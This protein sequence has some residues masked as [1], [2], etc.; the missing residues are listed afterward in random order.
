VLSAAL[1]WTAAAL[2]AQSSFGTLVGLVKNPAKAQV[3]GATVTITKL[4][5]GTIR[6]TISGSDGMYSFSDV[7]PG[8]YSVSAQSEGYTD[9]TLASLQVIAG[10]ATRAD[11]TMTGIGSISSASPVS[12][13]T[14]APNPANHVVSNAPVSSSA[15]SNASFNKR[16]SL[17]H[18][19]LAGTRGTSDPDEPVMTASLTP[20]ASTPFG[21]AGEIATAD[22]PSFPS[23]VPGPQA[24]PAAAAAP[25]APAAPADAP[26]DNQTPFA[27]ADFTWMNAV[28][29]NHDSV[30]DGKYFSGEF[31]VDTN[32][33]F[34]GNHPIDHT[35]G[36]TTEGTR[37]GEIVLQEL[38]IGGD[39]HWD[40]MQGR[41]LF[42]IGA[43]ATAV[44]RNDA[45]PS[46]GQWDIANACRYISEGYAGYHM[47]VQHGLNF[48]AGIFMSYIG[49]FS[50]YSFDNWSYQPSYVS[51]NTPWFFNGFRVQWFPTNKLKFEPW[52]INGW[53]SYGKFNGKP[54]VGGQI[55]WR[56]TGNL[57]FVWN[58]Y[59]LGQDTIA[60]HR[61][62]LHE[63]DSLE[64]KYYDNPNK[65]MH[66][67]AVSFTFDVGCE[68]GG[69]TVVQ[70][71]VTPGQK[72]QCFTNNNK[73]GIPAQNFIGAMAYQRW[74]F[75]HDKFGA[76]IGGGWMSNEGRYL[77]LLPPINGA[78]AI[79]GTPYFTQN[80]GQKFAG[81]D[82]Q[83]TFDWMP[84]QFVTWRFEFTQRGTNVPYF[85]G[86]GGITPPGGNN[87]NPGALAY[88]PDGS[89]WQPD[90]RKDE[91]RFLISLMVHL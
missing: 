8:S 55:L 27:F 47:D 25:A 31:R 6:A 49:L 62:R 86:P 90:L 14:A 70:G 38:N 5:G 60:T 3:A 57:D 40:H 44:P 16:N 46:V 24:P 10:K 20:P 48:Q 36:G 73:A 19:I 11:L 77:V 28:P 43:D 26:V 68:T 64:W 84:T 88:N 87:G 79:T 34:D 22:V 69:G 61:T 41:I 9:F 85:T 7:S 42:Q 76:T 59:A 67:M 71:G 45:S 72:V 53:Q 58:T 39:F 56:P 89:V 74:T 15:V 54:G 83:V 29:R 65:L 2:N 23:A 4:D 1:L 66:R 32:Y 81:Y 21:T 33:I 17:L 12:S 91:K 51:S 75:D 37:T 63:D 30:L 35:L 18:D 78:T 82:Y 50:Y 52:L 80:P 13:P